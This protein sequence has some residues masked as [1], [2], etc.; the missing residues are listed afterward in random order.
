MKAS[1]TGYREEDLA[2][3]FDLPQPDAA[4]KPAGSLPLSSKD[5][6]DKYEALNVLRWGK[7]SVHLTDAELSGLTELYDG[8]VERTGLEFG[9]VADILARLPQ[10]APEAD[11]EEEE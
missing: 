11:T 10:A 7:K 6:R 9:F 2:D 4:D 5:D 1:S 8:Y 3:L